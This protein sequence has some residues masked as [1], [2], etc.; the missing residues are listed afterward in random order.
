MQ[1]LGD[2]SHGNYVLQQALACCRT[3]EQV[4]WERLNCAEASSNGKQAELFVSEM[5]PLVRSLLA[6]G[7]VSPSGAALEQL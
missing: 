1:S 5:T 7:M 2:S 6:P 4:S 3:S